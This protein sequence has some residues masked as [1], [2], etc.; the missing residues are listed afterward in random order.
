MAVCD[1]A[2]FLRERC[3]EESTS[4]EETAWTTSAGV[5]SIGSGRYDTFTLP[6]GPTRTWAFHEGFFG[7]GGSKRDIACRDIIHQNWNYIESEIA[8]EEIET[9]IDEAVDQLFPTRFLPSANELFRADARRNF[10]WLWRE[11]DRLKKRLF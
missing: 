10:D 9:E 8:R 3:G 6:D 11:S 4:I 2:R 1:P 5:S 7:Q